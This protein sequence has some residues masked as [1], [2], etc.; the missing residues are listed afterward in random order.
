MIPRR[1]Y[2]VEPSFLRDV[3]TQRRDSVDQFERALA[4]YLGHGVQVRATASGRAALAVLLEALGVAR[5][6]TIIVPAYTL[7]AMAPFIESLGY[8]CVTCDVGWDSPV[9]TPEGLEAGWPSDAHVGCVLPTHLFGIPADVPAIARIAHARGAVVIED[10]AH[11]IGSVFSGRMTGT[12][13]DGALFSFNYLKP[14]NC[15]GGGAAVMPGDRE[16]AALPAQRRLEVASMF[17]AGLLEDLVFAGPWLRI[18]TAMLAMPGLS[19]VMAA[20]DSRIR[21]PAAKAFTCESMSP[22]QAAHGLASLSSY[23]ERLARRRKAA[24]R[25]SVEA[26]MDAQM[27]TG[28]AP[29]R[30]NAYFL[31]TR[32]RDAADLRR[33]LWLHGID[34]GF[35]T[36]VADYLQCGDCPERPAARRWFNETVQIPCH[37]SLSDRDIE[38]IGTAL[39]A[40]THPGR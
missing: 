12:M 34:A 2:N 31:T 25:I 27:W 29:G 37:E 14:V 8:R 28:D 15:F 13:G 36:E 18:P 16:S 7:G 20:V 40:L 6:S 35:G 5:G 32:S 9:M 24:L 39:R 4:A 38:K 3:L 11:S 19:G 17:A 22:M 1:R 30:P 21:R 10:C 26:G 33:R 23:P